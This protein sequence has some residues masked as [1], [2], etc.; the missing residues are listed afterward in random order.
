MNGE[1]DSGLREKNARLE[2]LLEQLSSALALKNREL[3]VQSALDQV[4]VRATAMR[5]SSELAETSAILFQQLAQ[6][7]IDAIRTGVG[8][9]DEP[10]DAMEIWL[11]SYS[12]SQEV[13]RILDYVNLHIHPVF[14]NIIPAR[15]QNKPYAVTLL[16][17]KEVR[18]YYLNMST[19]FSFQ[20]QHTYN[21]REFFYSFFFPQGAINVVTRDALSEEECDIMI[22]FAQVF[23]LIYTRFLDLQKAEMQ[24]REALRQTSLDRV[25]AEIAS[26]RTA[27]DL[28]H[29]PPVIWRELVSLGVRFFRCGIFIVSEDE[30]IV[31]AY[32]STPEGKSLAVLHLPFDGEDTT[33]KIVRNWRQKE[34]YTEHWDRHQFQAWVD[35]LISQGQISQEQEFRGSEDPVESLNLQLVP[36]SQGMLYVGSPLPL[37]ESQIELVRSIADTFSVAYARY[38]DFRQL[39]KA[40]ESI[41]YA[42]SELKS[43]Q[44]QLIQSEKMASLGELTAGIAHEIQNPLNFINNFAE[45]NADLSGEL[46]EALRSGRQEEAGTIADDIRTNADKIHHHGKRADAI[47]KSMLQQSRG[48]SGKKEPVDIN[49]FCVEYAR[50]AY[51]GQRARDKTFH[52]MMKTEFDDRI[53]HIEIVP[54]DIGNVLINLQ[55]NAFYAIQQKQKTAPEDYQPTVTIRTSMVDDQMEI[56]VTDNGIGIPDDIREK[57]FQ[58]FFTTKPPGQGTGLGLSLCYDIVRAHRGTLQVRSIPGELTEFRILLP[59]Q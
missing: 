59:R 30:E 41:A 54:H 42:M 19:Y 33:R 20:K 39:E 44:A 18:D 29:I 24:T 32:L 37:D 12:H 3:E 45:I 58:P 50:L 2:N 38:E 9:F 15:Q 36:F 5:E 10:N 48:F 25:R 46:I 6:L 55:N 13:V 26:M 53:G 17:G 49:A 21:E 52:A 57:I 1:Q 8:I 40:N 14:E 23:G 43:T 31:H 35:A 34:E 16:S 47:V 4:R 27:D 22:R 11:T 7:R 51:Y 56:S 28:S